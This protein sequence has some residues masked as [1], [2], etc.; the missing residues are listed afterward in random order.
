VDLV[1]NCKQILDEHNFLCHPDLED[2][3][4]PTHR[5]TWRIMYHCDIAQKYVKH[6]KYQT[7]VRAMQA[8]FKRQAQQVSARPGGSSDK[9]NVVTIAYQQ[10]AFE[11]FQKR[12]MNLD[13]SI[14]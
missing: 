1:V 3:V 12:Y 5:V 4:R 13:L 8:N 14:Q 9:S 7:K 10:S 6:R 2:V 11:H